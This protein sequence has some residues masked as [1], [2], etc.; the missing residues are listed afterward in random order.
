MAVV[1]PEAVAPIR[2][3]AWEPPYAEGAAL[4]RKQQQQKKIIQ[5]ENIHI[6]PRSAV[7]LKLILYPSDLSLLVFE[8]VLPY[9]WNKFSEKPWFLLVN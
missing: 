7:L 8:I 6:Y 3:L 5:C 9:S 2:P 1:W 4:K